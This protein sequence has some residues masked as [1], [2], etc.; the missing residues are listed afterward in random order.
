MTKPSLAG[1]A[2]SLFLARPAAAHVS[3][4]T[5]ANVVELSTP[6]AIAVEV[7]IDTIESNMIN[8]SEALLGPDN[9]QYANFAPLVSSSATLAAGSHV[10]FAS[11]AFIAESMGRADIALTDRSHREL[12]LVGHSDLADDDHIERRIEHLR[13]LECDGHTSARQAEHDGWRVGRELVPCRC[14]PVRQPATG[15]GTICEH[16]RDLRGRRSSP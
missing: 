15:V 2:L 7:Q 3:K 11:P 12:R 10:L 13:D 9:V 5:I 16:R 4:V 14:E 1:L 6:S 8:G